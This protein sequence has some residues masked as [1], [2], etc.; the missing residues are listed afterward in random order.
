MLEGVAR[1]IA[2]VRAFFPGYYSQF[3]DS[4]ALSAKMAKSAIEEPGELH[5]NPDRK[6]WF[7][8]ID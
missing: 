6:V 4:I 7:R 2:S 8:P 1:R 5:E 3:L